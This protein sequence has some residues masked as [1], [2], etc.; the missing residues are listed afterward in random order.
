MDG[1]PRRPSA[2]V[3]YE[4]V[5]PFQLQNRIQISYCSCQPGGSRLSPEP[6]ARQV[7]RR[8][9]LLS[10]R[11]VWESK[12]KRPQARRPPLEL[13]R[14]EHL[15]QWRRASCVTCGLRAADIT[16]TNRIHLVLFG[17]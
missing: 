4:V 14:V 5:H 17:M 15:T 13:P 16:E 8:L 9:N 10:Q 11:P 3:N 1:D 12:E 6:W 7:A 2:R